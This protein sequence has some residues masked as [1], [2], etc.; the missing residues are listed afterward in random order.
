MDATM[1]IGF[2]AGLLTTVSFFPQVVRTLRTRSAH[3][4][5]ALMLFL[6]FTGLTLWLVYGLLRDDAAIVATN[7]VTAALVAVIGGV[8]VRSG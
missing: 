5:S 1:L 4:F 6:L 3:D 7:G 2:S 8:K